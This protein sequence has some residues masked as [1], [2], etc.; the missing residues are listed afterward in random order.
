MI[1]WRYELD[2]RRTFTWLWVARHVPS[3]LAYWVYIV[4]GSRAMNDTDI[5]PE[6]RYAELLQRMTK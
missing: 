4:Q 3:R 5:V 1:D 6:V 2:K